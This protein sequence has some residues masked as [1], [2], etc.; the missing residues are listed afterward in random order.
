L[1]QNTS[2]LTGRT[3]DIEN[4]VDHLLKEIGSSNGQMQKRNIV[5]PLIFFLPV[6]KMPL[7]RIILRRRKKTI[8]RE[9]ENLADAKTCGQEDRTDTRE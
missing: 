6:A 1:L 3:G 8:N 4:L 7:V 2:P 9:C 5:R